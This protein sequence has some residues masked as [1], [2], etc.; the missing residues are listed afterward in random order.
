MFRAYN[1]FVILFIALQLYADKLI[2]GPSIYVIDS[3]EQ[4]ITG[5]R[6]YVFIT[7]NPADAPI[8][9]QDLINQEDRFNFKNLKR[10][11]ELSRTKEYWAKIDLVSELPYMSQ[12]SV[13][14][15]YFDFVEFYIK[16]PHG[17]LEKVIAG[18]GILKS[19]LTQKN[20]HPL[21]VDF[22]IPA[23]DTINVYMKVRSWTFDEPRFI[24]TLYQPQKIDELINL[25]ERNLYQGFFH[26]ILW[27]MIVYNLFLFYL[28]REKTYLYTLYTCW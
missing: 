28:N 21:I 10:Y 23:N 20:D 12:W 27:I 14:L 1:L 4:E 17:S 2:A 9:I 19:Q 15:G 6:D 3:L 11:G 8:N 25:D 13:F 7:E 24:F 5:L 22:S 26:G 16:K 18:T